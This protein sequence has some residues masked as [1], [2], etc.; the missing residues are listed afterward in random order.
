MAIDL[1]WILRNFHERD[2]QDCLTDA[3]GVT[4]TPLQVREY[5]EAEW[6]AGRRIIPFGV[7]EGFD[8]EGG[9]CPGHTVP[10]APR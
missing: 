6:E 8:Y 4:M 1:A 9:G 3:R 2:W 7:C 5:F 10:E